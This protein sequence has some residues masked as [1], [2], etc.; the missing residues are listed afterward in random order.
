MRATLF[1]HILAGTVGLIAGYV[2]LYAAKGATVHR[3]SGM[4]FV[5]AMIAMAVGG[6]SIAVARSVAPEINV[7]AA[8]LTAYLVITALVT[9]RPA[10][11][12]GSRLSALGLMLIAL[13]V[14]MVM[15]TFAVQAV[16]NGGTRNGMPAF[17][18][19]LFATIGLLGAGGDLRVLRSGVRTGTSRVA[20]HLWRMSIAL[21]IA[22]LSFAVQFIKMLPKDLRS[23]ALIALPMLL[24]LVPMFYWLWR[25]RVRRSLRNLI[26]LRAAEAA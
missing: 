1:V 11:A 19:F 23:P 2:A 3:K 18:F 15:A 9:V 14:G 16:A 21:F 5:Y 10:G 13:G 8:L 24:V 26:V 12:L 17:P 25:V 4:V 22:A 7:P 6:L 20:R